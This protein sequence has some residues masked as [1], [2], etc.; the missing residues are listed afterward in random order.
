MCCFRP[1]R[2]FCAFEPVSIDLFWSFVWRLIKREKN[3]AIVNTKNCISIHKP[4]AS[5]YNYCANMDKSEFRKNFPFP[6]N[7]LFSCDYCFLYFS[8]HS[9]G[10]A[11]VPKKQETAEEIFSEL[12]SKPTTAAKRLVLLNGFVKLL[13]SASKDVLNSYTTEEILIR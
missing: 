2:F 12:N 6:I 5:G 8:G 7:A 1:I 3:K 4:S 10:E 9:K 13:N 11:L